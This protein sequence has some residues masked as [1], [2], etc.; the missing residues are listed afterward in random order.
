VYRADLRRRRFRRRSKPKRP[1]KGRSSSRWAI[2]TR[3]APPVWGAVIEKINAEFKAATPGVEIVTESYQDQAWQ[4]RWKI[5]ATANQLPD[6]MK[7]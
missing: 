7:Y 5:Y 2:R 1:P 3:T 4:E 6:V